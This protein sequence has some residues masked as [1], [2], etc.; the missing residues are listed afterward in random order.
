MFYEYFI[1]GKVRI[2]VDPPVQIKDVEM[3]PKGLLKMNIKMVKF[4][5]L[6]YICW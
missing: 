1:L 3:L 6:H 5:A 4:K 2:T